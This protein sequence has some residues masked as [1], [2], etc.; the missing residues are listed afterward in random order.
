MY[1][2]S[3]ITLTDYPETGNLEP[4]PKIGARLNTDFIKAMGKH[5]DKFIIILLIDKVF[6]TSELAMVQHAGEEATVQHGFADKA[7]EETGLDSTTP[8]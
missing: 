3:Y 2:E 8:G 1:S 7:A 6:S 4:P 5:N